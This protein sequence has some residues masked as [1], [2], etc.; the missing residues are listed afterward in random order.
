MRGNYAL[1]YLDLLC[2]HDTQANCLIWTSLLFT[3]FFINV[4]APYENKS[5]GTDVR[6]PN[7]SL[8]LL[9]FIYKFVCYPVRSEIKI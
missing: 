3:I 2:M 8:C 9:P 6:W 7:C 1:L 4:C 5:R